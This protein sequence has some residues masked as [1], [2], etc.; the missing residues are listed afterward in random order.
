MHP[1]YQKSYRFSVL[2]LWAIFYFI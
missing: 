1:S 2:S